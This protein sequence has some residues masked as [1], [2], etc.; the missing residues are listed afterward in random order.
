MSQN[1]CS[2]GRKKSNCSW[3]IKRPHARHGEAVKGL[4]VPIVRRDV[5]VLTL[6]SHV[7]SLLCPCSVVF[8]VV[9]VVKKS[10]SCVP[11]SSYSNGCICRFLTC[12]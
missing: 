4:N 12:V 5:C 9:L 11:S 6:D 7:W 1:V 10:V 8:V 3:G 2:S